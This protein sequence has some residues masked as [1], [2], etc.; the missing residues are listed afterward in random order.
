[1]GLE[2]QREISFEEAVGHWYDH[3]YRP[4]AEGIRARG[5]LEEFPGRT[6]ADLYLWVLDHR[7]AL[8]ERYGWGIEVQEAELDLAAT[9]GGSRLR[10][11]ARRALSAIAGAGPEIGAWR[12]EVV[13]RRADH[14]LFPRVLVAVG[15]DAPIWPA[16]EWALEFARREGGTLRGLHV[17]PGQVSEQAQAI[18][19]EFQ[20]RLRET[21][22]VG[23][24]AYE[25]GGP[26]QRIVQRS[27]WADLLVVSLRH[28]PGRG[29]WARMRSAHGNLIRRSRRPILAVPEVPVRLGTV[30]LAFDGGPRSTEAL[31]VATYLSCVWGLRLIV[32][33]VQPPE[34]RAGP[35]PEPA[36]RYLQEN[37]G[38]AEF[39][40][41]R[42]EIAAAV[43]AEAEQVGA[44]V[45]LMGGYGHNLLSAA[46]R[47]SALDEV[48]RGTRVPLLICS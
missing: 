16:I 9:E 4:I 7:A 21:G 22:V 35:D 18:T 40:E 15:G 17:T 29:W 41:R 45:I 24:I 46:L 2:Q 6:E 48:L 38:Q 13:E 28:P 34:G 11:L 3:V 25:P 12:R 36:R 42:G 5:V 43:L 20:R 31:Y 10:R 23:Q 39:H 33:T 37:D 26:A 8:Q 44:D 30:L 14:R 27:R 1:M 47:G 32:L 19:E